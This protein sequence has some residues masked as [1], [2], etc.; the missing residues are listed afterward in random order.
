MK[1]QFITD[2]KGNK[3]GVILSIKDYEK[4]MDE[5]DEAHTVRMYDKTKA[6]KLAFRPFEDA[7]KEI[8]QKRA[9]S[10]VSTVNQ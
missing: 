4:L 7:L 6:E 3:T 1:T 2:E 10:R 5:L 9:K 8:E